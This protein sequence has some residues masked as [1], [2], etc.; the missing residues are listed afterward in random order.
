MAGRILLLLI[1]LPLLEIW[2]LIEVGSIIGAGWTILLI[3]ATTIIGGQLVRQQGLGVMKRAREHQQRG[4]APAVP[5]LEGLALLIA[6]FCLILPGLVTDSIGF[7]LL[8]PPFRSWAAKRLLLRAVTIQAGGVYTH[9]SSSSH[10][11]QHRPGVI[12][13]DYERRDDD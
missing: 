13:G 3:V 11:S 4:E 6:G 8:I 10:R 2:L 9:H 12:E 7:L 1:G 5:M